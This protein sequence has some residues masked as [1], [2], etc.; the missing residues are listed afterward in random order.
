MLVMEGGKR[1]CVV[2]HP[3]TPTPFPHATFSEKT[4]GTF[5]EEVLGSIS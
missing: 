4:N 1:A 2:N 3:P 5:S